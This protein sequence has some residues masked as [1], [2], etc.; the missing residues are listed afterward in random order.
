MNGVFVFE[1][2]LPTI[3]LLLLKLLETCVIF[4][5]GQIEYLCITSIFLLAAV[6]KQMKHFV[7]KLYFM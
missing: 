2:I 7:K 3:I 6:Q 4:C 5:V 1:T